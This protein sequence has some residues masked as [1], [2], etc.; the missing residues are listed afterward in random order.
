MLQEPCFIL[1]K[2]VVVGFKPSV[3]DTVK[4]GFGIGN[5]FGAKEFVGRF[6][7]EVVTESECNVSVTFDDTWAKIFIALCDDEVLTLAQ[8]FQGGS[9]VRK[10]VMFT[11]IIS[12]DSV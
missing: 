5:S 3:K 4:E 1:S 11:N 12:K 6:I 9:L 8:G 7:V 2:D 10:E